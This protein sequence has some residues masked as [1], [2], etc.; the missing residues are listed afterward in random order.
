MKN[1]IEIL[2]DIKIL[3]S[4]GEMNKLIGGI[5]DNSKAVEEDFLFFADVLSFHGPFWGQEGFQNDPEPHG[6]VEPYGPISDQI[7]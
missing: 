6:S 1:L 4:H 7:L 2:N 3:S 5:T